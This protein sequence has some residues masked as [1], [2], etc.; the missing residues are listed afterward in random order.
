MAEGEPSHCVHGAARTS[1]SEP[2]AEPPTS[3]SMPPAYQNSTRPLLDPSAS[4]LPPSPLRPCLV[5]QIKRRL[6]SPAEFL[7]PGVHNHL[8]H[9]LL[10]SLR[11]QTQ[12]HFLRPRS[13][14]TNHR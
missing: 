4:R 9:P 8:P 13:R 10:A 6:R 14:R 3:A 2:A 7:K 5:N 12:P 11:A 1:S